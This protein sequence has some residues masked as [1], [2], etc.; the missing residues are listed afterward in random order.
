MKAGVEFTLTQTPPR[1][2][3]KEPSTRSPLATPSASPSGAKFVPKI[4]TIAP[5][6]I[7]CAG[8][9]LNPA[10]TTPAAEI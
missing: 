9:E 3:G 8:G 5:G 2:T 6:E 4:D 7:I 1:F 10:L